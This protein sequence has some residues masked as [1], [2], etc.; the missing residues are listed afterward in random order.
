M[1]SIKNESPWLDISEVA[2]RYKISVR[3]AANLQR[4]RVF[5]F[6]KLGRVVRFDV[7]ECDRALKRHEIKSV[8]N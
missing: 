8:S 6:V 3:H 2:R 4:R 1:E 5:P 7:F